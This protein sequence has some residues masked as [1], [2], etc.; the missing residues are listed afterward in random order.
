MSADMKVG[1][2][3]RI[4][5][6]CA[7]SLV[8]RKVSEAQ[9]IL[10]QFG[11]QTYDY[12]DG[13]NSLSAEDYFTLQ[14]ENIDPERL[15][16][17]HQFLLGEDAA[18]GRQKRS[19]MWGDNPVRVFIS[20][21]HEDAGFASKV[22]DILRETC[23]I[24]AFVAHKD[25]YPSA[26]WRA[27]IR[28]ALG[29]A[30]YFVAILHDRFHQSEWCDQEVGW[31][32]G[33][34]LPVLPVR[35]QPLMLPPGSKRYDGFIEEHQDL[36]LDPTRGTGE[37][38]L[39]HSILDHVLMDDR[40]HQI[41]VDALIEAFVKS[42]SFDRTRELWPKIA[43]EPIL[44]SRHLRRLEY[45]AETNRQVYD[46]NVDG[47]PVP[48]LVTAVVAKVEPPPPVWTVAP[49]TGEPPF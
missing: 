34:N 4:I 20:H 43:R 44:E 25:I 24:D 36:V 12:E 13:W 42:V 48:D 14:V 40:T 33:R 21:C 38:F 8:E 1:E 35:R 30:H 19:D 9:M 39:A 7:D 18:P 3:I 17:L 45:A 49:D 16:E 47:I 32:L 23:G 11:V 22:N 5:T 15:Y 2:R 41:G 28:S 31:A 6:E 37:W 26:Q 29:T 27:S 46:A 10:R